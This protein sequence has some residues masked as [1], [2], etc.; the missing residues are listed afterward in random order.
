MKHQKTRKSHQSCSFNHKTAWSKHIFVSYFHHE[1]SKKLYAT[2]K[3]VLA[4]GIN[5]PE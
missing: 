4:P 2:R 5:L 3:N 1:I